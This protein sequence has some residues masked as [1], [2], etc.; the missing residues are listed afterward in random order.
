MPCLLY[1]Q[2]QGKD[3][4][5]RHIIALYLHNGGAT[6]GLHLIPK[7][8]YEHDYLTSQLKMRVDLATQVCA[9]VLV[10][11]HNVANCKNIPSYNMYLSL[12]VI[13]LLSAHRFHM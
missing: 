5:W 11:V 9:C 10:Y 3:I 12:A 13:S 6:T 2:C 4:N 8:K 1:T 7:L